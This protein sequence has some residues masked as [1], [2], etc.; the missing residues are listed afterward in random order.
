[1]VLSAI[2]FS[3]LQYIALKG[4]GELPDVGSSRFIKIVIFICS[5]HVDSC[6]RELGENWVLLV[7]VAQYSIFVLAYTA[8]YKINFQGAASIG[9]QQNYIIKG[10]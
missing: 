2:S 4:V 5:L 10:L 9:Q 3:H 1:M 8:Y 7:V 6:C